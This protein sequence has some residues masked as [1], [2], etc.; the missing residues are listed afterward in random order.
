M[1]I[2]IPQDDVNM[3]ANSIG[4][5]TLTMPFNYLGVKV[6]AFSSRTI[7]GDRGALDNPCILF[8]HLPWIDINREFESLSLKGIN[9]YSYVKKRVGNG[10][11][12]FFWQDSWFTDSPLKHIYHQLYALDRDIHASVAAKIRDTPMINSF[13]RAPRGGLEEEQLLLLVDKVASVILSSLNDKWVWTLDSLG[14]YLVRS[15]RSYIDDILLPTIGVSTRW[16]NVIPININI[17]AWRVC[18]DKLPTRL[19]LSLREIDILSILCPI[20]SSAGETTSH[21]LFSCNV[22]RNI[23]LKVARWW[24]LEIQ[25]F[26]SYADWLSWFNALRLSKGLKDVLEGVFYVMSWEIWKFR[27]QVLF[28]SSHPRLEFLFDEIGLLSYTWCSSRCKS[29]FDWISWMKCPSSLTL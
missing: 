16:V 11:H 9:L 5:T 26:H 19:N 2:G 7:Y 3:A 23:L 12:T 22:A 17:F 21:L 1:G 28:G 4:C 24:E 20:C 14:D 18:L 6:G 8:R 10:E 13:R 15:A 27:N 29:K 25:D